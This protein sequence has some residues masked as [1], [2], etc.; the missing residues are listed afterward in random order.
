MSLRYS[1]AHLS[2]LMYELMFE[3]KKAQQKQNT[4]LFQ[5]VVISVGL[6][7]LLYIETIFTLQRV[8]S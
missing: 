7:T 6:G 1:I 2:C 8:K 4:V 5:Q 3:N